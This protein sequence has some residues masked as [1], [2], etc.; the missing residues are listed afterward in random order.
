PVR[1]GL[2]LGGRE[3]EPV[4]ELPVQAQVAARVVVGDDRQRDPS[5]HVLLD[6]LDHRGPARQRQI[7]DV[8]AAAGPQAHATSGSELHPGDLDAV[9]AGTLEELPLAAHRLS[10]PTRTRGWCREASSAP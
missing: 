8:A 5:L 4:A 6:R 7:E 9:G 3:E 10:A 2:P 1:A